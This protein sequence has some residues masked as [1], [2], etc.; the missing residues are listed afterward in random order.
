MFLSMS[1]K[2]H[3]AVRPRPLIVSHRWNKLLACGCSPPSEIAGQEQRDVATQL[4]SVASAGS[5][6][7]LILLGAA[8]GCG[9]VKTAIERRMLVGLAVD[10]SDGA[11]NVGDQVPLSATATF[12]QPP[13]S[14]TNFAAQWSSSDLTIATIDPNTGTP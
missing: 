5:L 7:A 13:I 1:A 4:W 9:G 11:A 14:E 10:P 3:I 6:G 12:N 8:M 2:C